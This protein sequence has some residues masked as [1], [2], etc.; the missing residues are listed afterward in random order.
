MARRKKARDPKFEAEVLRLYNEGLGSPTIAAK[1]DTYTS[2]ITRTL[3]E[4]G[5]ELRT[6]SEAQSSYLVGT[7]NHP[8]KG[9]ERPVS[10][11]KKISAG[12][13]D[14]WT[15]KPESEKDEMRQKMR[16][17]WNAQTPEF[18]KARREAAHK[19]IRKASM[20]G[21]QIEKFML[22]A[23]RDFGYKVEFHRKNLIPNENLE[24]DLFLP[25]LK[26]VI[27]IDGPTHFKPIWGEEKLKKNQK[28]DRQKSGLVQAAGYCM[29]RI[30]YD[31]KYWSEI[32]AQ[33]IVEQVVEHLEKIKD[34]FPSPQDR[35]IEIEAL[36]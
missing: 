17:I 30:K 8:T 5:V 22:I 23:L 25:G 24:L 19:A 9:K 15:N 12:V 1:L 3:K 28:A 27:E 32:Q 4:M 36:N 35:F 6:R 34:K 21:S 2:K 10:V 16:D 20:E 7:D 18:H 33:I 29:L 26:T 11:R 14:T 13:H 31:I